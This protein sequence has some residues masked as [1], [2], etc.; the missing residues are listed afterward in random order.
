[1]TERT[2]REKLQKDFN[3]NEWKQILEACFPECTFYSSPKSAA[4]T[5]KEQQE[6]TEHIHHIGEVDLGEAKVAF[7][8]V[9]LKEGWDYESWW[10]AK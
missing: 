5:R 3:P 8:D 4:K 6:L 7:I 1:M 9:K 2:L 10:T